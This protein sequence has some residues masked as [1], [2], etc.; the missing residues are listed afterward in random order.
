MED[1]EDG[2]WGVPEVGTAEGGSEE[3]EVSEW[4]GR[5]IVELATVEALDTSVNGVEREV[6]ILGKVKGGSV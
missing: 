6:D 2:L 3:G 1:A 5:D 4:S